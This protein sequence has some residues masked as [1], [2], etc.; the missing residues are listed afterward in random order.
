MQPSKLWYSSTRGIL[1]PHSPAAA[2]GHADIAFDSLQH[3]TPTK[4]H[5]LRVRHLPVLR[6]C[7]PSKPCL[8]NVQNR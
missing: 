4:T 1:A 2:R 7:F 3:L 8:G 6:A 5:T